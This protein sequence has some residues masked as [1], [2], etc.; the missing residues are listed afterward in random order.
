MFFPRVSTANHSRK[1]GTWKLFTSSF[2]EANSCSA[3]FIF[4][5]H[6]DVAGYAAATRQRRLYL[7]SLNQLSP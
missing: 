6:P 1:K 5:T 2:K 4:S 3:S 7:V